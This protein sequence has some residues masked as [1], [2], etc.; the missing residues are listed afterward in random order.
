MV[1]HLIPEFFINLYETLK[2]KNMRK[3]ALLFIVSILIFSC[4]KEED[5][6]PIPN[7]P[8]FSFMAGTYNSDIEV[9]LS[10]DIENAVIYYT[11][12]R[13]EPTESS[14]I[15]ASPIKIK[16]D[17]TRLYIKAISKGNQT[18]V[19][20]ITTSYYYIDYSY[21]SESFNGQLSFIGY[22]DNIVGT[23]IGYRTT[24]WT[25]PINV[26]VTFN[27][28]GTYTSKSLTPGHTAFYYGS[29]TEINSYYIYELNADGSAMGD[30]G[31]F[32]DSN[33]GSLR[34]IKFSEDLNVLSFDFWHRNK[35]GPLKY[36][37]TRI[38]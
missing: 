17:G 16:S 13:T 14:Y 20:E 3:I 7:P 29:D 21:K 38:E 22:Q 33:T 34:F 5:E 24:P 2:P 10:S 30:I 26:E 23:W 15:Y 25:S 36:F 9:I 27:N 4:E 32:N 31:R 12:D 1:L 37:I 18:E 11:L 8:T 35:Y 28:N 6:F 19:S